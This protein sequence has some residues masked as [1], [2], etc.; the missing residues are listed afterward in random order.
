M[1]FYYHWLFF[2]HLNLALFIAKQDVEF[3]QLCPEARIVFETFN[4]P[5]NEAYISIRCMPNMVINKTKG[6]FR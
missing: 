1:Y 4:F 2:C 5:I 3:H 6:L